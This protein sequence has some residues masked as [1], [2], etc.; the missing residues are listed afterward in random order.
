MIEAM[1][2][3][4]PIPADAQVLEGDAVLVLEVDAGRATV[5]VADRTGVLGAASLR[6]TGER[7]PDRLLILRSMTFWN[8]VWP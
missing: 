8:V 7:R 2:A 5:R 1:G 6:W 4:V 3:N